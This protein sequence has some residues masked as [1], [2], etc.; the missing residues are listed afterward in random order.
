MRLFVTGWTSLHGVVTRYAV[1]AEAGKSDVRLEAD[2]GPALRGEHRAPALSLW[3][4]DTLGLTRSAIM[5][6]GA[7]SFTVLPKPGVVEGARGLL[8]QGGDDAQAQ[9]T[10]QQPTEGIFRI[11][12]YAPGDDTRRIHWVRSLQ[13]DKLIMRL[14]DEV[15]PNDPALRLVLDNELDPTY[16]YLCRAPSQLLDALV[17]VWLGVGSALTASGTRVTLVAA[18]GKAPRD[19]EL[20]VIERLMNGRAPREALRLGARVEWQNRMS[21]D[22]L[23]AR[24]PVRQVVVSARPRAVTQAAGVVEPLWIVVPE[25]AW[26]STELRLPTALPATLPFPI[27]SAENR[28]GRRRR[29]RQRLELVQRDRA[30]FRDALNPGWIPVPGT[31]VARP[32]NGR[33]ALAVI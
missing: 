4:A 32:E 3:L 18:A 19:E 16:N 21:L 22:S 14:P 24:S 10:T 27:G 28:G 11:R 23:L 31:Y 20:A 13:A 9:P 26:T 33:V 12:E 7:T 15:P 6:R 25:S 29:E 2:L 17:H 30:M 8:G 1:G 5:Y